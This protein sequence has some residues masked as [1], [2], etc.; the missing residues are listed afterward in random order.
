MTID[1]ERY[2]AITP[3]NWIQG[4][5]QGNW[6]YTSYAALPEDGHRY[7]I[8]DGVLFMTP[9][10]DIPH[11]KAV[12]RLFR[13]LAVR[14]EDIGLGQVFVASV[15]I[16]LSPKNVFEPDVIVVLDA[17]LA[18]V[19]RTHIV[20]SPDLVVEVASPSTRKRDRTIKRDTYAHAGIKEYWLVDTTTCTIEVLFLE[21]GAYRSAGIFRGQ[22]TL[23]SQIVPTI[24]NVHAEQCFMVE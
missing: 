22:D 21:D 12:Q 7:E 4:P 5:G 15:D 3:A 23:V 1:V 8:V 11:Q 20:G 24:T 19:K 10:P 6:T 2:M 18:K 17:G 16:E 13:H 14:I 9:A